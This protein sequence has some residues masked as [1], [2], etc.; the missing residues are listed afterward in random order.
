[1]VEDKRRQVKWKDVGKEK[2]GEMALINK[3]IYRCAVEERPEK[4]KAGG[5][6][7]VFQYCP[8]DVGHS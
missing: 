7:L 3:S 5:M 6:L 2:K 4:S 1:M 8:L